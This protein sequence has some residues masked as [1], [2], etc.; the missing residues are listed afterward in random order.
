[1]FDL[2]KW[3][4]ITSALKKNKLRTILTGSGVMFGI[5]ILVTLLG[6]GR[7]F[8]NKMKSSLGNLA[9]NSTIF[10][11]SQTTKPYKGLPRNR[12]FQFDNTDLVAMKHLVQSTKREFEKQGRTSVKADFGCY[13]ELL[14]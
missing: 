11:T 4:E 9:T 12:S 14:V 3:Q 7:G 2:D 6:L 10:W 13:G 8:Q 1:M 5:L